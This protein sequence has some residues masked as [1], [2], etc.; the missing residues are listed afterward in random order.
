MVLSQDDE[1]QH[2]RVHMFVYVCVGVMVVGVGK[3]GR[4]LWGEDQE[5]KPQPFNDAM[6]YPLP[7]KA[8]ILSICMKFDNLMDIFCEPC[9]IYFCFEIKKKN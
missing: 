4:R 2:L 9:R 3:G 7:P 1:W 5:E 6:T 8:N